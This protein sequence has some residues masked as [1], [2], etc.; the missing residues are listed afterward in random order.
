MNNQ[1]LDR[2]EIRLSGLGGQGILT[3][4]KVMGPVLLWG[5]AICD[6]DP[7]LRPEARGGASRSDL[8]ISSSVI[9]YP[10]AESL[11]LLIAL[12]QEACNM[13]YRN[14][15]SGG[16]LMIEPIWSSSLRLTSLSACLLR[17][18]PKRSWGC[19]RL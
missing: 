14:L 3:L 8:V 12:S 6:S 10:K 18:L 17:S 16:L 1:S 4:G 15:K 7:E 13:Y 2:F 19:L 9:S 11:D 5:M